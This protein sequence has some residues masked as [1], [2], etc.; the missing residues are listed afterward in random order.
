MILTGIGDEAGNTIDTQIDALRQL[1]W[2]HVEMRGVEV[3]GFQKA[4]FHDLPDEAFD[5]AAGKLKEAGIGIYCF[6]TTILNWAAPPFAYARATSAEDAL[7]LL[8]EAGDDAKVLAGG[9]SLLPLL[10]YRLIR[11]SHLVDI[12]GIGALSTARAGDGELI[13]DGLVRHAELERMQLAGPHGLLREA[14]AAI[15]HLP[16]RTRG[17][18]AGSLA[19]ADPAAEIPLVAVALDA[20]VAL[21]SVTGERRVT[22]ESFFL[23][24]FTTALAPDELLTTLVVP[25]ALAGAGAAF[26]E[27]AIRAGDFAIAAAAV[28]VCLDDDR[29]GHIRIVL[30]GV[31]ATPLRARTAETLLRGEQPSTDAVAAAAAAAAAECDPASDQ[32]G[33]AGFR[34]ELVATLTRQCLDRALERCVR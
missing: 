23:G 10:A 26:A 22:A 17:T 16:I 6:G 15:G 8:A 21:R 24:P 19:H 30:G 2:K 32:R 33:N 14:A 1:G 28:V 9:Q 7:G 5:I 29:V 25:P 11:P 13:V 34:R 3:P 4:N 27:F 18:V 12:G 20:S 31:E